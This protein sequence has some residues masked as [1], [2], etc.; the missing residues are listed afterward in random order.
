VTS[1]LVVVRNKK[2]FPDPAATGVL[3]LAREAGIALEDVRTSQLYLVESELKPGELKT[4]ASEL[5][6][7]A[8]TQ[9]F[10]TGDA[11][12]KGKGAVIDVWLKPQVADPV[13]PFVERG[14]SDLCF[15]VTVR[16]GQRY[17][18]KGQVDAVTAEKVA[19][20]ALANPILHHCDIQAL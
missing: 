18:L 4:L 5:L 6:A 10:Q 7:D 14:A 1:T 16:C 13:A 19:W 8:V 20:R 12:M 9:E 15:T 17:E 3:A 2:E 11:K